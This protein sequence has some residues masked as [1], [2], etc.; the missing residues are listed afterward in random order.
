MKTYVCLLD[1]FDCNVN[2]KVPPGF[3]RAVPV[4]LMAFDLPLAGRVPET[5][6]KMAAVVMT[7][8]GFAGR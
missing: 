8:A 7:A 4:T 3:I 2:K 6:V 5:F 1:V